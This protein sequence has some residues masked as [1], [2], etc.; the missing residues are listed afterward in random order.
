VKSIEH[1]SP[2]GKIVVGVDTHKDVHVAVALD[3]IGGR[4]GEISV[5]TDRAGYAA[6][7][8]WALG[9][10]SVQTFGIEGTSSYGAGLTGFLRRAGYRVV[11]V[12]RPDRSERH[13]HG[14]SDP[15]DA[16]NA[17]RAVLAGRAT[18][19]P[20]SADGQVEMLRLVKVV[21]DGA[22]KARS[23]ALTALRAL[24]VTAPPEL[25]AE[26]EPLSKVALLTRCAMLRPGPVTSPAAATKHALRS[27]ARRWQQL[28]NEV[29]E[30]ERLLA[31]LTAEAAPELVNAYGIG[32]DTAADLLI[33]VGDNRDR[34]PTEASLAKLYGVCPIPAS[35]GKTQRHRLNRG[36]NRQAN[37][38]LY[39]IVVVRM[40]CHVP[41]LAYVARRTTDGKTTPEIMR[42]LKRYVAREVWGYLHPERTDL[43]P[44]ELAS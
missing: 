3:R 18:G 35:S 28:T 4:L 27:L 43:N 6:L 38:A 30:H 23:Q 24:L 34:V 31:T 22:V 15:L 16:E 17:A 20:K 10:G 39:R 40:R 32:P 25:R 14:K 8:K 21:K 36:G 11:E 19:T 37:A 13:R 12:N 44:L 41:T 26:L 42:C 2:K 33:A 29:R 7:E 9:F 5:A 1:Q